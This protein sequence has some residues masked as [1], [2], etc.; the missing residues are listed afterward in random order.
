MQRDSISQIIVVTLAVCFVCSIA[1]SAAAVLLRDTQKANSELARKRNILVAANV[2]DK[3][4]A[5]AAEIEEGFSKVKARLVDLDEARFIDELESGMNPDTYD[6]RKMEKDPKMSRELEPAEDIASMKRREKFSLVYYIDSGETPVAIF[7]VRGYGLWSTLY[8]YIALDANDYNT[9]VGITFYEHAETPGLGGEVDN[10]A[11]KESWRGKKLFNDGTLISLQRGGGGGEAA[12]ADSGSGTAKDAG[13]DKDAKSGAT[14]TG[15]SP[16]S[17]DALSGA[18]I[19]SN[20]INNML[21]FWFGDLGFAEFLQ[22][23]KRGSG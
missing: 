14:D 19:T 7:P 16:S 17:V 18:T 3:D 1:V 5:S 2:I 15:W 12:D 8:A 22:N 11:W 6:Q 23:L 9:I 13:K 21:N 20:G 4:S 10:E